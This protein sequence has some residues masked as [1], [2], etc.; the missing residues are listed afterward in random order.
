MHERFLIFIIVLANTLLPACSRLPE[1]N[2]SVEEISNPDVDISVTDLY[3]DDGRKLTLIRKGYEDFDAV[4]MSNDRILWKKRFPWHH[5]F[6]LKVKGDEYGYD[7][8]CDG[9]LEV[10]IAPYDDGNWGY[11]TV[12]V[13]TVYNDRLS[14]YTKRYVNLFAKEAVFK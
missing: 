1:E 4:L 11:R 3:F 2:C 5:T 6:F 7:L 12:H 8:N 14:L 13:Y 9:Y 10:V